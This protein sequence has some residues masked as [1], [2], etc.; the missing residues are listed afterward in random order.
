[1][2]EISLKGGD[3]VWGGIS[4]ESRGVPT[5]G[6]FRKMN[7]LYVSKDGQELLR[8]PGYAKAAEPGYLERYL[9]SWGAGTPSVFTPST[10]VSDDNPHPITRGTPSGGH[11]TLLDQGAGTDTPVYKDP[12]GVGSDLS[13]GWHNGKHVAG[14]ITF[15]AA[16]TSNTPT[17][18]QEY[19]YISRIGDSTGAGSRLQR[20]LEA[21]ETTGSFVVL[22]D[23]QGWFDASR[24]DPPIDDPGGLLQEGLGSWASQ[25]RLSVDTPLAPEEFTFFPGVVFRN[26]VRDRRWAQW[27][28]KNYGDGTTAEEYMGIK[29]PRKPQLDVYDGRV[30][31]AAPGYGCQFEVDYKNWL[32]ANWTTAGPVFTPGLTDSLGIPK[33]CLLNEVPVETTMALGTGHLVTGDVVYYRVA[34]WNPTT[35]SFGLVS[36][37][38]TYTV[39]AADVLSLTIKALIPQ[40]VMRETG[41]TYMMLFA[42]LP[43]GSPVALYHYLTSGPVDYGIGMAST[44]ATTEPFQQFVY[45]PGAK[46]AAAPESDIVPPRF[47]DMPMGALWSKNM[48]GWLFSGGRIGNKLSEDYGIETFIG[49]NYDD[50]IDIIGP[51]QVAGAGIPTG[52]NGVTGKFFGTSRN[53]LKFVDNAWW[54]P[55][56]LMNWT[57]GLDGGG[58]LATTDHPLQMFKGHVQFSPLERPGETTS[59]QRAIFDR[60]QGIDVI[61]CGRFANYLVLCTDVET[62]VY[63]WGR[64]PSGA[65]PV[66][67]TTE[68]GAICPIMVET[69]VGL[70]WL[71][72]RGPVLFDGGSVQWIGKPVSERFSREVPSGVYADVEKVYLRDSRGF[73]WNAR[74]HYDRLEKCVHWFLRT[75]SDSTEFATTTD[76]DEQTKV[77]CDSVLTWSIST[78]AFST[79]DDRDDFKVT[80]VAESRM[81]DGVT[82]M[83]VVSDREKVVN[84]DLTDQVVLKGTVF[85][86]DA[87][88]FDYL[89]APITKV[90]TAAPEVV[91]S[92][93]YVKVPGDMT[94]E[95][96]WVDDG[97]GFL[98][99]R[100][101]QAYIRS[102]T[103][104]SKGNYALKWWG[105]VEGIKDT[106][107]T[108]KL[109]V[110]TPTGNP[111]ASWAAA[112]SMEIGVIHCEVETILADVKELFDGE[113]KRGHKVRGL[114]IDHRFDKSDG[115]DMYAWA[116][117]EAYAQG[118]WN[119]M[120]PQVLG[121]PLDTDRET[122]RILGGAAIARET[123]IRITIISNARV[124][125]RD[126]RLDVQE[127]G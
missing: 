60:M 75:D 43:N 15:S 120:H 35:G 56:Y 54:Q 122:T 90:V 125:I 41:A 10:T 118:T 61:A 4:Y 64:D 17:T 82:R 70:T 22:A 23:I 107:D 3:G 89:E 109:S 12:N 66:L 37:L 55:P 11:Y 83:V 79:Y 80:A 50:R 112:D 71:S 62:Y 84:S 100:K 42:S 14:G 73:M 114:I 94:T 92:V 127:G 108:N 49:K 34:Y 18:G 103:A 9:G 44:F 1:M 63:S 115:G 53:T 106:T 104:D 47:P 85:A 24:A 5:S 110:T 96:E 77:G 87:D 117:V 57:K 98:K 21:V 68:Y 45:G 72:D 97:T 51:F 121:F 126:I 33:G 74:G 16:D 6:R 124:R 123:A 81:D 7:G 48:R 19:A 78:D 32:L 52:F 40:W 88:Y 13:D 119:R 59:I 39:V 113:L 76:N 27:D 105:N 38:Y 31:I 8:H 65:D 111:T 116:H 99:T 36:E 67:F 69:E 95:L 28:L 91:S 20:T 101:Y 26:I 30:M 46:T 102:L 58:T 86:S 93:T 2:V 29:V 25:R